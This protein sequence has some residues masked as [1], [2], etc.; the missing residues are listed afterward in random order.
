[1]LGN[2]LT[3]VGMDL[4]DVKITPLGGVKNMMDTVSADRIDAAFMVQ[5]F[6]SVMEAKKMGRR[7][8]WVSDLMSYQIAAIFFGN[9]P[10]EEKSTGLAFMRAYIRAC[11]IYHDNCLFKSGGQLVRG[12]H[13]DE[14]IG[15]ISKYTGRNPELIAMGLNYND[16]DGRLD[17]HD[18]QKQLNWYFQN[19]LITQKLNTD[20]IVDMS[21]WED[22]LRSLK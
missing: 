15:Y 17:K 14:I 20:A 7:M 4:K 1:M 12:P 18:I 22:A 11:R 19:G 8:L 10:I 6:C 3:K 13:F 5:P 21:I 2:M 9:K 16:R